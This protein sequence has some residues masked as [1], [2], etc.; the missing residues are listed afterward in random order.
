ML[1]INALY[2]LVE[3]NRYNSITAVANN[4]NV[5]ASNI[6]YALRQLEDDL[7]GH[8]KLYTRTSKGI[9]MT[10]E[11]TIIAEMASR[12]IGGIKNIEQ[13]AQHCSP[14][15][16][17]DRANLPNTIVLCCTEAL[18]YSLLLLF[19]I[20]FAT[21]YPDIEMLLINST[22]KK[23]E[24]SIE[25]DEETFGVIFEFSDYAEYLKAFPHI[26]YV[27][28]KSSS[29]HVRVLNDSKLI[30][31]NATQ[32]TLK[33][34]ASQPLIMSSNYSS[35]QDK[36]FD[37]LRTYNKDLRV[38]SSASNTITYTKIVENDMA[39]GITPN[40]SFSGGDSHETNL[41][42][43]IPI[44]EQIPV[45]IYFLCHK[46]ANLHIKNLLIKFMSN[47]IKP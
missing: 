10:P 24:N 13:F 22:H 39:V 18:S 23:M 37:I 25:D 21:L 43:T 11:G 46:N 28:L 41:T 17:I 29:L 6:T 47:T 16:D 44:A 26:D 15:A 2:Y 9:A 45:H 32:I 38:L 5:C 40:I 3:I 36:F 7:G 42:R 4:L 34:L 14:T 30:S 35:F 20:E 19:P 27:I 12:V 31:P 1:K 33:Q 8:I